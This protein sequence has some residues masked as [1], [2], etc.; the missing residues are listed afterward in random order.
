ML[1]YCVILLVKSKDIGWDILHYLALV[2]TVQVP[3]TSWA[4]STGV[5][6]AKV[7]YGPWVHLYALGTIVLRDGPFDTLC[8]GLAFFFATSYCFHA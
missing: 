1:I 5:P 7:I 2:S 8:S 3:S 6:G 4:D